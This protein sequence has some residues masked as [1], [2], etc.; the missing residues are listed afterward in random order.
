MDKE[1]LLALLNG[2]PPG[3]TERAAAFSGVLRK[4][5]AEQQAQAEQQRG[6]R[7]DSLAQLALLTGDPVLGRFGEA[8]LQQA[9]EQRALERALQAQAQSQ[10]LE[11]QRN[12]REAAEESAR[13]ERDRAYQDKARGETL[14]NQLTAAGIAAG[15]QAAVRQEERQVKTEEKKAAD[16]ADEV[17]ELAKRVP[18]EAAKMLAALNDL[19]TKIAGG[20]SIPGVGPIQGRAPGFLLSSEGQA[21]RQR[22]KALVRQKIAMIS[23]TAASDK[24][25]EDQM[26]IMGMG[27][28]SNDESFRRGLANLREEIAL[29]IKQKMS[30][31]SP[32]A[33]KVYGQR[34]GVTPE[35]VQAKPAAA[36]GSVYWDPADR[37]WKRKAK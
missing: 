21:V 31:F 28:T 27:A 6:Q 25:V 15:R 17:K 18:P 9:K 23:G 16:V 19:D 26:E 29:D 11:A 33:G 12:A 10:Q 24:E 36:P 13:W 5:Q 7:G 20:G 8:K 3:P 30:G 2:D 4:V 22:A 34:G 14:Q 35:A 32:E 37:A 1:T